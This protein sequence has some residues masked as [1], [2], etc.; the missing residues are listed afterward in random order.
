MT[1]RRLSY[2]ASKDDAPARFVTKV[3]CRHGKL[4]GVDIRNG[5]RCNRLMFRL[6]R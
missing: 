4:L 1:M 6:C 2:Y 5:M 3:R